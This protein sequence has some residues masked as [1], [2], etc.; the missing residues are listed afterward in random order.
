MFEEAGLA[1]SSSPGALSLKGRLLKDRAQRSEGEVRQRLL[2]EA[3]A[4]Y[5]QAAGDARA[6]YPLI[7]AATLALL[8]GDVDE[9]RALARHVLDLLESGEH[10]PETRYW[11]R[12]TAAEARLLLGDHEGCR[13][14]LV[15]AVA[16]AP[17]AWEDQAATLS[18]FRQILK[19]SGGDMALLDGFGAP[20]S[21]YYSGIIGL[22][23]QEE[24]VRAQI[25]QALDEIAPASVYG[26]LAAGTDILVAEL[27]L[28]RG[29]EL[30]VVLPGSLDRF[31]EVS[32]RA[33]GE[34]WIARFDSVL[35]A[36]QSVAHPTDRPAFSRAD[37]DSAAR[38]A[39]GLAIRHASALAG[40]AIA[41]RVGREGEA[42]APPEAAWAARGL[43]LREVRLAHP[44]PEARRDLEADHG[45][46]LIASPVPFSALIECAAREVVETEGG[47]Y[48]ARFDTPVEAMA[49]ACAALADDPASQFGFLRCNVLPGAELGAAGERATVLARAA[50]PGEVCGFWPQV[51]LFDL[52]APSCRFEMA[53]EIVSPFGDLPVGRFTLPERG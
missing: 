52:L 21:L 34:G 48:L 2:H 14:A 27:A 51:A 6:T 30:H 45:A 16:S 36:A 28:D 1:A 44:L 46:S 3:R 5:L 50:A 20:P 10:E 39:M 19:H 41:L 23:D 26:A 9:A 15:E 8:G 29:A 17:G 37:V 38:V 40:S 25:A 18:Q 53:G 43:P 22:S 32:V 11:L 42:L 24:Q 35:D 47:M 49:S 33:F 31:R 7:N 12:A 4:A 13:R